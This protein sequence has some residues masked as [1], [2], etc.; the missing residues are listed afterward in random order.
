M[1]VLPADAH[2]GKGDSNRTIKFHAHEAAL[3]QS[4]TGNPFVIRATTSRAL[5]AVPAKKTVRSVAGRTLNS[6]DQ[7][8]FPAQSFVFFIN[9]LTSIN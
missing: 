9:M 2:Q 1:C 5:L 8:R 3:M 7:S 6:I 4:T